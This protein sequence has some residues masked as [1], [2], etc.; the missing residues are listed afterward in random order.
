MEHDLWF[1]NTKET[2]RAEH[3]FLLNDKDEQDWQMWNRKAAW[4]R[5]YK[6]MHVCLLNQFANTSVVWR[7]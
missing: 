7:V 1:I 3:W 2:E 5:G 6:G 4:N